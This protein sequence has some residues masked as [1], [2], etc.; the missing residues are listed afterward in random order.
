EPLAKP[1]KLSV[2]IALEAPEGIFSSE[3]RGFARTSRIINTVSLNV[4]NDPA[5]NLNSRVKTVKCPCTRI[6]K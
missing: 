5:E 3:N 1:L 4:I 2:N 6:P